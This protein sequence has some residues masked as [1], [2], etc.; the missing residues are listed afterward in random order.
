[1]MYIF[2]QPIGF[3]IS[4]SNVKYDVY[5]EIHIRRSFV[6]SNANRLQLSLE[7]LLLFLSLTCIQHHKHNVGRTSYCYHLAS[8]PLTLAGGRE[9]GKDGKDKIRM[10]KNLITGAI[11]IPSTA[12][13]AQ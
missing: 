13:V 8:A 12:F 11:G 6:E 5:L 3:Q 10:G 9:E 2:F 4:L 7:K 1:M